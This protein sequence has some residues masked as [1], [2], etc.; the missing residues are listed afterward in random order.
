MTIVGRDCFYYVIHFESMEDLK[1][2]CSEGSWSL[3]G[4]LLVLEKW[5]P[6]LV[7]SKLHS[8]FCV[9]LGS[10]SWITITISIP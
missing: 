8:K 2:M 10:A 1:Y 4:V 9:N 7:M 5:R 3:D 6:N